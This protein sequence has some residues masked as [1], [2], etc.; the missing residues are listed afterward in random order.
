MKYQKFFTRFC[1]LPNIVTSHIANPHKK[2]CHAI[3]VI[4]FYPHIQFISFEKNL[5]T[6]LKKN[7]IRTRNRASK[8]FQKISCNL[9]AKFEH[10]ARPPLPAIT[11]SHIS[12]STHPPPRA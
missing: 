11:D 12:S 6:F 1:E 7:F 4:F 2:E 3:G 9:Q 8:K 5:H 10:I